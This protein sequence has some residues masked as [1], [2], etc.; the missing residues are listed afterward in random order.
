ML[1]EPSPDPGRRRILAAAMFSKKEADIGLELLHNLSPDGGLRLLRVARSL[2]SPSDGVWVRAKLGAWS[3]APQR[4]R[5][6]CAILV[7]LAVIGTRKV[8]TAGVESALR[9]ISSGLPS[10]LTPLLLHG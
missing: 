5:Q 2:K 7:A 8:D 6:S 9:R 4:L 3:A 1:T 10:P